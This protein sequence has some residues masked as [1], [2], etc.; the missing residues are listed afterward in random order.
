MCDSLQLPAAFGAKNVK[1]QS[2]IGRLYKA[3]VGVEITR[4]DKTVPACCMNKEEKQ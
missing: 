2:G 3:I 1:S 4:F